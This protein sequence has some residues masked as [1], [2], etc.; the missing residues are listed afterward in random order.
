MSQSNGQLIDDTPTLIVV[1][2]LVGLASFCGWAI[3]LNA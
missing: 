3:V 1:A 2:C